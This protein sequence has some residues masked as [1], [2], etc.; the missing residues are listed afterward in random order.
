MAEPNM[1]NDFFEKDIKPL[2]NTYGLSR[3][4][5]NYITSLEDRDMQP[6]LQTMMRLRSQ[7]I[8]ERNSD[9]AYQTSLFEFE[10]K[11]RKAKEEIDYA[12]RTDQ[13]TKDISRI[14]DDDSKDVF[15]KQADLAK[16]AAD[17][18]V[19]ISKSQAANIVLRSSENAIKAQAAK[20]ADADRN[21]E[22]LSRLATSG[23]SPAEFDKIINSDGLVTDTEKNFALI[24]KQNDA[25]AVAART[26]REN[27]A[28]IGLSNQRTKQASD[29]LKFELDMID[30]DKNIIAAIRKEDED[31]EPADDKADASEVTRERKRNMERMLAGAFPDKRFKTILDAEKDFKERRNKARKDSAAKLKRGNNVTKKDSAGNSMALGAPTEGTPEGTPEE[32]LAQITSLINTLPPE[33]REAF[34]AQLEGE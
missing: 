13:V 20:K 10:E 25:K 27:Q 14:V 22:S 30:E 29:D 1:D 17:N 18:A 6:Q 31:F 2:R 7:L 5:S 16:F 33:V 32:I 8:Q 9:L 23:I 34:E 24:N 28:A 26:Y 4:E 21:S 11:K 15:Q 19:L 12:D 3:R